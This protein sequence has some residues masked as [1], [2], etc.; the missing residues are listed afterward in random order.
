LL[1]HTSLGAFLICV[2]FKVIVFWKPTPFVSVLDSYHQFVCVCVCV[3]G[4]VWCACVIMW[5]MVGVLDL[6]WLQSSSISDVLTA[7]LLIMQVF[8]D[9]RPCPD[10]SK[11]CRASIFRSIHSRREAVQFFFGNITNY[12]SKDTA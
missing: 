11:D 8:W 10:V 1:T 9:V 12:F 6:S 4:C 7:V 5:C 2:E 3:C